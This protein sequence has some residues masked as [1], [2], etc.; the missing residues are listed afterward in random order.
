MQIA[1]E[2]RRYVERWFWTLEAL[3]DAVGITS[4]QALELIDAGC[5]PGPI[6][7]L[8]GQG[9]WSA[10]G[11]DPMPAG[12]AWYAP[13]ATWWLRRAVRACRTGASPVEAAE[14]AREGFV[15]AFTAALGRIPD[16][17]MAFPDCFVAGMIDPDAARVAACQEWQSWID[18]GY[19]VCLRVF[20][21]D[22]CIAKESLGAAMKAALASGSYDTAVLLDQA[23]AL[24]GLILPFAPWQRPVGTP[25]RTIDRLL[26]EQ[27][28]GRERPYD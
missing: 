19:G 8:G 10:L 9:W 1:P 4:D 22:S 12:E 2:T 18:G 14:I 3:A 28:L 15:T 25:G 26:A 11:D 7:M 27:K 17:A 6:Y 21:P 23:E 16:A 13:G 24:A 5:A 20:T